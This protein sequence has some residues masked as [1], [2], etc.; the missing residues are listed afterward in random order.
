MIL[1][2][3]KIIKSV[4]EVESTSRRTGTELGLV[5]VTEANRGDIL[6]KLKPQCG[7]FS[8]PSSGNCRTHILMK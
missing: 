2:I 8:R 7:L 5:A 1:H 6:V 3:E 4:K